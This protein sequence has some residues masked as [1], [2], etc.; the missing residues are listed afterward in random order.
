MR[1][2]VVGFA[3]ALLAQVAV[4]QED[5]SLEEY[6]ALMQSNQE[7]LSAVEAAVDAAEYQDAR[8]SVAIL[9]RN[10]Q[11]RLPR[12]WSSRERADAVEIVRDGVDRL[13]RLEE[14]MSRIRDVPE[15][16][17]RQA[18]GE[19]RGAVCNACHDVYREGNR[20]S[21]FRFREGVF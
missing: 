19:F 20:E 11:G 7:A 21:G 5:I 18:A 12:F 3:A 17:V 10:F 9:R 4:G 16:P 14:L 2:I 8:R 1:R 6:A 15:V 13:A